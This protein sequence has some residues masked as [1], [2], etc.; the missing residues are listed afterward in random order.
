MKADVTRIQ[1]LL[2]RPRTDIA[3]WRNLRA[4]ISK[5]G[6]S[7]GSLSTVR[8]RA[9]LAGY[10]SKKRPKCPTTNEDKLSRIARFAR[11]MKGPARAD[12]A[13]YVF[14]DEWPASSIDRSPPYEICLLNERPRPLERRKRFPKLSLQAWCAIGVGFR[15]I[16]LMI[17]RKQRLT[18]KTYRE[19][20]LKPVAP[21]LIRGRKIL[22]QDGA[23][24][25]WCN[26]RGADRM[27]ESNREW[28]GSKGVEHVPDVPAEAPNLNPIENLFD[29]LNHRIFA[30][31]S[32]LHT[33]ADLARL[34][35]EEFHAVPQAQI[36]KLCLS[37]PKRLELAAN[38]VRYAGCGRA[39]GRRSRRGKGDV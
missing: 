8:R 38:D 18:A 25:H 4:E 13:R 5:S 2:S 32:E 39:T 31:Q 7:P 16:V 9:R 3:T 29:E 20:C 34:M 17:N 28:L 10:R 33:S 12:A 35:K 26:S 23:K 24:A 37:F 30:R 1:M 36:D 21:K 19:M 27:T 6:S 22:Y 15:M 11:R 14:C